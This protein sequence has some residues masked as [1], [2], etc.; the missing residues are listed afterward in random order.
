ME[1]PLALLEA[2]FPGPGSESESECPKKSLPTREL[3]A[4]PADWA[5]NLVSQLNETQRALFK[6]NASRTRKMGGDCS[7]ADAV[8]HAMEHLSRASHRCG[9]NLSYDKEFCSEHP[10]KAGDGPRKFLALNAKPKIMFKDM[11]ARFATG[12]DSYTGAQVDVP[13]CDVYSAGWV[14]KALSYVQQIAARTTSGLR[15]YGSW[16]GLEALLAQLCSRSPACAE[17]VCKLLVRSPH[18]ILSNLL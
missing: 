14:C 15:R 6:N 12:H 7:G 10:G 16:L 8:S 1:D 13:T 9:L 4:V 3:D 2:S 17:A 11:T 18:Y 5:V